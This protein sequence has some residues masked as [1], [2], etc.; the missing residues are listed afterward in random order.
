[1]SAALC[2]QVEHGW[3]CFAKGKFCIIAGRPVNK[4]LGMLQMS[5][6]NRGHEIRLCAS[7]EGRPEPGPTACRAEE[8]RMQNHLQGQGPIR[9][10][11]QAPC[12]SPLPEEART[13]RHAHS[14]E[15]RSEEH[16]SE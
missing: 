7:I 10:D 11:D 13:R 9:S 2:G 8:R 16:T 15:T 14:V 1:M 4:G 3:S 6:Q 5:V 12:P